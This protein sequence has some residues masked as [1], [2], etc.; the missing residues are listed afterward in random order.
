[1]RFNS[2]KNIFLTFVSAQRE[3][4]IAQIAIEGMAYREELDIFISTIFSA[5]RLFVAITYTEQSYT[6]REICYAFM[7][8]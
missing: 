6:Q 3:K 7:H 8:L 1:M 2:H 4:K 5:F